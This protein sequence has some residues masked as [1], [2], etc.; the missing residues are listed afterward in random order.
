MTYSRVKKIT[1]T[2]GRRIGFPLSGPHIF[3]HTF[4]TRLVRGIDCEKT[5]LDVVQDL[6]GHA[7]I[8]ST[9]IYTHDTEAAMKEALA[10]MQGRS[11]NLRK[12]S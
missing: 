2:T 6:L 5:A 3:R 1:E 11:T 8:S 9:R 12:V 4:A 7:S 10:A